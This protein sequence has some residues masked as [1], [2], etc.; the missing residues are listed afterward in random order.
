MKL[1]EQSPDDRSAQNRSKKARARGDSQPFDNVI[2]ALFGVDATMMVPELVEGTDVVSAENVELDRSKLKADLVFRTF[3][4]R[5]ETIVDFELQAGPD[6]IYRLLQYIAALYDRYREAVIICVVIYLFRCK[7]ETSP[8]VMGYDDGESFLTVTFRVI[9]LWEQDP[10]PI[11]ARHLMPFYILL[12][13]MKNPSLDLLRQAL[14]EMA[15]HYSRPTLG[16]RLMW[17]SK[18]LRRTDTMSEQDKQTIEEELGMLFNYDEL[19][20][21]DPVIQRLLAQSEAEGEARGKIEG[22]ARGEARGKIEGETRG[23]IET[24]KEAVLNVL[25]IRFSP[26]LAAKAQSTVIS[27]QDEEALKRLHRQLLKAAD[28]QSA[29]LVLALPDE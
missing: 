4:K 26:A 13:G 27:I 7:V 3:R 23:K 24:L 9:C 2:K 6:L 1:E 17:F 16:Y 18:I 28:E 10:E 20:R 14:R 11:V 8:H 19:I 5:R 21:D 25:S 29:R 12:P 15:Q 22:E